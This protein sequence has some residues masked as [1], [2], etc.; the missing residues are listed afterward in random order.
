MVTKKEE[1][2]I[3]RENAIA[4]VKKILETT[5]TRE[6][7]RN[8]SK[9]EVPFLYTV[10][11]HVSRSGMSRSIDLYSISNTGER[12]RLSYYAK[13]ILDLSF[14]T[15]NDG[16]KMSGCGMDMGFALVYNLASAVYGDGYAIAQEWM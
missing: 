8:G 3:E 10:L 7:W 5:K 11:R 4:E 9:S 15:K 2:R 16:V 12:Y 13:V 1:K 6:Q 14:D